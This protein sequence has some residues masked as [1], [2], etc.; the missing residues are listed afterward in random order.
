MVL[1]SSAAYLELMY[2]QRD[3]CGLGAGPALVR[4]LH[5]ET[6]A[7]GTAVILLHYDQVNPLAGPF[8]SRQGYRPLWTIP[9]VRPA[10][11]IR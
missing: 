2:V 4:Q 8:W 7:A 1:L 9:E 10:N 3:E 5:Q 6:A 11:A